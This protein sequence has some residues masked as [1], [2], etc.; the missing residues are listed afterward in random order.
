MTAYCQIHRKLEAIIGQADVEDNV[1]RH[2]V[3]SVLS[4][5]QGEVPPKTMQRDTDRF[6]RNRSYTLEC[7]RTVRVV[8]W[9]EGL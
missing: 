8:Q 3:V 2:Q 7:G 6:I 5:R 1:Y 4:P 9:N